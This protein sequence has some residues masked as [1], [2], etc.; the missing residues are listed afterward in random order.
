MD[1]TPPTRR[2]RSGAY[3]RSPTVAAAI[4][5]MVEPELAL[6]S[7][8]LVLTVSDLRCKGKVGND[9]RRFVRSMYFDRLCDGLGYD[10]FKFRELAFEQAIVGKGV[11]CESS[12][13]QSQ[14]AIRQALPC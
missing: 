11:S 6:A 2:R 12:Q 7:A 13:V 3:R 14:D 10:P 1:Q 8:V 4:A 5:D 9:A